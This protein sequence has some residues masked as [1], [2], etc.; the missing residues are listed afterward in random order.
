MLLSIN[1]VRCPAFENVQP[2][3]AGLSAA[4]DDDVPAVID[5]LCWLSFF[6]LTIPV[7]ESTTRITAQRGV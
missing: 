7:D 5:T 3:L 4:D 6:C 1:A 2:V